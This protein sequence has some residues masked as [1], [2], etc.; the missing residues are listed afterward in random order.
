MKLGLVLVTRDRTELAMSAIQS[1]LSQEGGCALDLIVSDN[2]STEEGARKLAEHCRS[3]GD[4]RVTWI[5]PPQS[6]PMPK[7][8]DWALEQALARSDA[9]HFGTQYDRKLWKP[10]ELRVFAAACA[11]DPALTVVAAYDAALQTASGVEAW[12]MPVTGR[13]YEIRSAAIVRLTSRGMVHQLGYAYPLLSNCMVPRAT[14][15]RVRALFGTICDSATPD[16]AFTYRH[17]AVAERYLYLDRAAVI[18]HGYKFSN[19]FSYFRG[20]AGGTYGDWLK[21]WGDRPWLDAAPIPGLDLGLNIMFHEYGAVQRV[22]GEEQ[23]PPIDR[24][25]Y[26]RELSY[27]LR[28]IDDPERQRE[29]RR[30][31]RRHGW[32]EDERPLW[33]RLLSRV[34]QKIRP[35][36]PAPPAPSLPTFANDDEAVHYLLQPRPFTEQNPAIAP[37]EPVEVPFRA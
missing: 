37:L 19:A 30:V 12:A 22:V 1:I 2:S 4:P 29:M 5:R 16:G 8:W 9:T 20:D 32:R 3:L 23:F 18:A 36:P 13:L 31:L 14:L 24:K 28:W 6:L 33:R 10:G 35:A 26:L 27:G 34:R 17:T 15:E 7:H 11:A 25:G 21:L